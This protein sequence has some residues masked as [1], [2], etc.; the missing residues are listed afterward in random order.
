[1]I[2]GPLALVSA[3]TF[4]GAALYMDV[5][6]QPARLRLDERALLSE[7]AISYPNGLRMQA[8]LAIAGFVL[9]AMLRAAA[10]VP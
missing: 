3:A 6:E 7:W 5:A 2:A 8:P 1:M 10:Q 4:A 9:A